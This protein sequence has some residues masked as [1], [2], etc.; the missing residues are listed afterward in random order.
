MRY[1]YNFR[2]SF[3][4]GMT[5]TRDVSSIQGFHEPDKA[6]IQS[7]DGSCISVD[8]R[9]TNWVSGIVKSQHAGVVRSGARIKVMERTDLRVR[10]PIEKPCHCVVGQAVVALFPG[11]AVQLE[12]GMFRRSR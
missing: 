10:W 6:S 7:R 8:G 3:D 11:E 1:A 4:E 5:M 12:A 9:I 2:S